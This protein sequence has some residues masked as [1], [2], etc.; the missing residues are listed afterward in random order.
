M[1]E[2][3]GAQGVMSC[4]CV[5]GNFQPELEIILTRDCEELEG[6]LKLSLFFVSSV[7]TVSR[8]TVIS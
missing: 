1:V 2:S 7:P 8:E 5:A 6:T 4:R 3:G